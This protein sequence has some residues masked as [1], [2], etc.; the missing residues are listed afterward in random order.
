MTAKT[1]RGVPS[2]PTTSNRCA[3][4]TAGTSWAPARITHFL[5]VTIVTSLN[6]AFRMRD[7]LNKCRNHASPGC[8]HEGVPLAPSGVAFVGTI[9]CGKPPPLAQLANGAVAVLVQATAVTL[10]TATG[11]SNAKTPKRNAPC[12][13]RIDQT[14]HPHVHPTF[15]TET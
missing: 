4:T 7:L 10:T 5:E 1:P 2:A 12:A 3:C 13:P 6:K 15:D 14:G 11:R 8:R 9:A